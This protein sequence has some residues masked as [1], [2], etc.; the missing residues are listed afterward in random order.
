[1]AS[2]LSGAV[3]VFSAGPA[4]VLTDL[5]CPTRAGVRGQCARSRFLP[6]QV[7][8]T[9]AAP[10]NRVPAM[11]GRSA[12]PP[13]PGSLAGATSATRVALADLVTGVFQS[14]PLDA[15]VGGGE[16]AD[17]V[18]AE[19]VGS[20]VGPSG[21]AGGAAGTGPVPAGGSTEGAGCCGGAGAG[22]AG[23]AGGLSGP[24]AFWVRVG[25]AGFGSPAVSGSQNN[26]KH[27]SG[28]GVEADVGS[29]ESAPAGPYGRKHRVMAR[30][31]ADAVLDATR[32]T[33]EDGVIATFRRAQSTRR[34]FLVSPGSLLHEER[35][36]KSTGSAAP[37]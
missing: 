27:W 8:A 12:G 17:P 18:A 3:V 23:A 19:A 31:A 11:M 24:F 29:V 1:M 4:P 33:G 34:G 16:T 6:N 13:S 2:G 10:S 9:P 7:K 35:G 15:P 37:P 30:T 5:S 28:D 32:R 21:S 20:V 36:R 14:C 26:R 22:S 25:S